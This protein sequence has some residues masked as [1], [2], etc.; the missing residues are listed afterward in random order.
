MNQGF[1]SFL[2]LKDNGLLCSC[3]IGDTFRSTVGR[4]TPI[5]RYQ[6]LALQKAPQKGHMCF[7]LIG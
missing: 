4:A 5:I 6:L 2:E 7:L 3:L 1:C